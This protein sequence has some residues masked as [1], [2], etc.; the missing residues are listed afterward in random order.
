MKR[1]CS[2]GRRKPKLAHVMGAEEASPN[3]VSLKTRGNLGLEDPDDTEV[4]NRIEIGMEE[5]G[6]H[7]SRQQGGSKNQ[8]VIDA[9]MEDGM[10]SFPETNAV[11]CADLSMKARSRMTRSSRGLSSSG[12]NP[13]FNAVLEQEEQMHPKE[14]NMSQDS[15]YKEQELEAALAVIR[16]VMKMDAAKPFNVPADPIALGIPEYFDLI[17]TGT[18]VDF[19]TICSNL[20][21]GVEYKNS[22]DVL[23][24]VQHIWDQCHKYNRKGHVLELMKQVKKSFTQLWT[25]AGLYW[26]QQED[27]GGHS[28]LP[29]PTTR[30]S[31]HEHSQS[32]QSMQRTCQCQL[33]SVRRQTSNPQAGTSVGIKGSTLRRSPRGHRCQV[34]PLNDR[35][36]CSQ[37]GVLWL[38][39]PQLQQHLPSVSCG[40]PYESRQRSCQ[41]QP[42]SGQLQ[43]SQPFDGIDISNAGEDFYSSPPEQSM[44]RL[45]K[46]GRKYPIGPMNDYISQG[47]QDQI[48]SG[49]TLPDRP[50]PSRGQQHQPQG[51]GCLISSP[52]HPSFVQLDPG[53]EIDSAEERF[54]SSPP[55]AESMIRCS[56]HQPRYL[57][58]PMTQQSDRT[59]SQM[60]LH[61]PSSS[62]GPPH[63]SHHGTCRVLMSSCQTQA[64]TDTGNAASSSIRRKGRGPTRCL[65]VWNT[66][67]KI[68][69]AT[70][71]LGQPIGLEAPKL[72]NFLGTIARNGHMAPLNYIDWRALP[73]E[74]KEKMWQQVQSKFDIDPKSKS[75][76]LKSIGTKWR[77][78]KANLKVVH[79]DLHETNEERLADCDARVLPDQWRILVSF[80]NSKE[81][82]DRSVTNKANR[83]RQK[84]SHTTGT[85]SFARIRE[86]QREK[87][88]DGKELSQA[89]LFIL[90]RTRK[91]GQPVNEAS[92]SI[93]SQL[94]ELAAQ[95]QGTSQNTTVEDDVFFQVM[96]QDRNGRAR[97]YGLGPVPSDLGGPKPSPA[98]ARR[99]VSEANAEVREMKERMMV[100]EQTCVQMA[101]QMA[102]M[103]SMMSTM[104]MKFPEIFKYKRKE[105]EYK[106]W[107]GSTQ[108]AVMI[109]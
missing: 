49:N 97:T 12:I 13:S 98:E 67:G 73:D 69:I 53:V 68:L 32:Y 87:R 58:S 2:S 81:A 83:R 54:S 29:P 100:M 101:A 92:S 60:K 43:H 106:C 18:P 107:Q 78:W 65:N 56:K 6:N 36:T 61:Q 31:M 76:I 26:E 42:T 66:E 89:E 21:N 109:C 74:N 33:G 7:R 103:M 95:H 104:Q 62:C 84:L 5:N 57:A 9:A 39:Q 59:P 63:D 41:C 45:T 105:A 25:E 50:P 46:R 17:N 19:G 91:D 75:W 44:I 94:R 93:I 11:E 14:P 10:R 47:H 24:D 22:K 28:H 1:K 16:K 90:T 23:R 15:Q 85:K 3:V 8:K 55:P 77:N 37:Q 27:I 34:D 79:Y 40:H 82:Q 4:N 99:I 52:L 35:P 64:A 72:T 71:E 38:S 96:G 86:E 20:Q 102:T 80:W 70:N 30:C 48:T 108:K 51:Q 88:P